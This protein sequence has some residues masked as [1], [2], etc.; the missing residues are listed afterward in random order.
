MSFPRNLWD[1]HFY[2]ADQLFS[3]MSSF[4]F[5]WCFFMN[6]FNTCGSYTSA[7]VAKFFEEENALIIPVITF[8]TGQSVCLP[9]FLHGSYSSTILVK[10]ILWGCVLRLCNYSGTPQT[11]IYQVC[12]ILMM[13]ARVYCYYDIDE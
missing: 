9:I 3:R 5:L 7:S 11:F 6:R 12:C 10:A 2:S 13:L 4:G 8:I 1:W